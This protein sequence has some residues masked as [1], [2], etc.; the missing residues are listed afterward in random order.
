MFSACS[1][2]SLR[3]RR[4]REILAI[5]KVCLGVFEK[6]KE[7]EGQGSDVFSKKV[8]Q[9]KQTPAETFLPRRERLKIDFPFGFE[10]GSFQKVHFL[11]ILENLEILKD[12]PQS[13]KILDIQG[14]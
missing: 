14:F 10:K 2:G 4:V 7:K 13:W 5:F 8:T 6:I 1:P 9:K 3:V 12:P 11:E